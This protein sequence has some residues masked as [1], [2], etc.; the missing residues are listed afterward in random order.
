MVAMHVVKEGT[1]TVT[2]HIIAYNHVLIYTTLHFN[3]SVS[4]IVLILV[5][6]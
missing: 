2:L 3:L 1:D 5:D 6:V 4:Y